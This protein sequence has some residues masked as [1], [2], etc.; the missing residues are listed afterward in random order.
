MP[1]GDSQPIRILLA[2]QHPIV[3]LGVHAALAA[4]PGYLI[5]AETADSSQVL[6]LVGRLQPNILLI[7]ANLLGLG[8]VDMLPRVQLCSPRTYA[9]VLATC[10]DETYAAK[11]LRSGATAFVVKSVAAN[12]LPEALREAAAGHRYVSPPLADRVVCAQADGGPLSPYDTLT[13]RERQILD[14]SAEGHTAG[15]IAKRLCVSQRT[16]EKHRANF[17]AKLGRQTPTELLRY[18]LRRGIEEQPL[19]TGTHG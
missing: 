12:A 1:S 9:V 4:H 3:I 10:A 16:V 15:S 5:M 6:P 18:F 19:H 13:P 11:I 7:D 14:L 8:G 17:S 2:H